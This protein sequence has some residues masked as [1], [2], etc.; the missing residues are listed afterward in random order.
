MG[1]MLDY[2]LSADQLAELREAYRTTHDKREAD[3]IK[4]M[5]ALATG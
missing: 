3:R 2:T 5:I 1:A 4:A